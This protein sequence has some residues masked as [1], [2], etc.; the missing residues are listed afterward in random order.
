MLSRPPSLDQIPSSREAKH[1]CMH[2]LNHLKLYKEEL[3]A[4]VIEQWETRNSVAQELSLQISR[5]FSGV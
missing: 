4:T 3:A 5:D 1:R 2:F